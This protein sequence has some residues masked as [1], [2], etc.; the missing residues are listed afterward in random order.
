M[1]EVMNEAA[2][3]ERVVRVQI[4][5]AGLIESWELPLRGS[6]LGSALAAVEAVAA[7]LRGRYEQAQEL[8]RQFGGDDHTPPS[9]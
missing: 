3:D 9:E 8:E 4:E 7:D 1:A 5:V 2:E 6:S